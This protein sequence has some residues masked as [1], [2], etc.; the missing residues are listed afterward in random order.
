MTEAIVT[1]NGRKLSDPQV[2]ALRAAVTSF[3]T[4][5]LT[6]TALGSDEHGLR[7]TEA[8]RD[9]MSEVLALIAAAPAS[10]PTALVAP[11]KLSD[12]EERR[13]MRI[14]SLA[15]IVPEAATQV[16]KTIAGGY[17][18]QAIPVDEAA[19]RLQRALREG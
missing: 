17:A 13:M 7:M 4:E 3:Y 18:V 6:P 12:L 16:Q 14:L 9:R 19:M 5:M 1:I 15:G 11:L 10:A 2:A 8:Y